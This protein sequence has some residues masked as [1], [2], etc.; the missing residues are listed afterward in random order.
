[1]SHVSRRPLRL[2]FRVERQVKGMGF[3]F[4]TAMFV[5]MKNSLTLATNAR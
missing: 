1:M 4:H 5:P 3:G 2:P